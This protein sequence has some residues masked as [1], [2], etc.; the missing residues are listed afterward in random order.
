MN[1]LK[2]FIV[3][4]IS[5]KTETLP[6]SLASNFMNNYS[7]ELLGTSFFDNFC[8]LIAKTEMKKYAFLKQNCQTIVAEVVH[9]LHEQFKRYI[10][11]ITFKRC[12][13]TF[14]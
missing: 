8:T 9:D 5:K 11:I 13:A 1:S 3:D 7:Y 10:D 14:R 6:R 4:H 2:E 12:L